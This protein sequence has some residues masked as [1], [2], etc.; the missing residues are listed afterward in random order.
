MRIDVFKAP[1]QWG[2]AESQLLYAKMDFVGAPLV[3]SAVA[4]TIKH[5]IYYLTLSVVS[6]NYHNTACACI[7]LY[8]YFFGWNELIL[9]NKCVCFLSKRIFVFIAY[10]IVSKYTAPTRLMIIYTSHSISTINW[11]SIQAMGFMRT[12]SG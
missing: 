10:V 8:Y 12:L 5:K 7:Q 4:R 1:Y 6:L 9:Y 3:K 2:E 11:Y